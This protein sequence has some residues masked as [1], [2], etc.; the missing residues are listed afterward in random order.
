MNARSKGAFFWFL[1]C[2]ILAILACGG[3]GTSGG[4]NRPPDDPAPTQAGDPTVTLIATQEPG[5]LAEHASELF[6][7]LP[8]A[9]PTPVLE[10]APDGGEPAGG[11]SL[12]GLAKEVY[13]GLGG[14][15]G[16]F[17]F[18]PP[19]GVEFPAM[20]GSATG[21]DTG[22]ICLW[23]FAVGEEVTVEI[24]D[25]S[26][27]LAGSQAYPVDLESDGV[28]GIEVKLWLAEW[29]PGEWRV[30]ATSKSAQLASAFRVLPP[31]YPTLSIIPPAGADLFG[32]QWLFCDKNT[33]ALGAQMALTGANFPPGLE[34]PLGIYHQAGNAWEVPARLIWGQRVTANEEGRFRTTAD[35]EPE[36]STGSHFGIAIIDPAY[37]PHALSFD[38]KGAT[39]CFVIVAD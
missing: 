8:T 18:A 17:C 39:A 7:A 6:F 9:T 16:G 22:W 19:D 38:E 14:G 28:G 27:Q 20:E 37:E 29:P 11:D 21:Y 15:D 13:I 36:F 5:Q 31:E 3:G 30:V 33:Y 12:E 23:G 25:P 10:P 32:D 2:L 35:L 4:V 26:G 34:L 24:Y 1:A